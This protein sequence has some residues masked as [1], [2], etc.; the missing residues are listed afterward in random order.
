MY[1]DTLTWMRARPQ[2][3]APGRNSTENQMEDHDDD[4]KRFQADGAAPL[5]APVDQG[6]VDHEGARIRYSTYGAG[7]AVI[8]LHGGL[9]HSGNW[10]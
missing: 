5:P 9:G 8:L 4:L 3:F 1:A 6:S 10:G 2:T 7:P